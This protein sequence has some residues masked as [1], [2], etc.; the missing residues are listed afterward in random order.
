MHER[1]RAVQNINLDFIWLLY[2]MRDNADHIGHYG[3]PR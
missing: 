2:S 1:I 3:G